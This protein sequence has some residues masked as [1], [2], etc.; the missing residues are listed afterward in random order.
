MTETLIHA[1]TPLLLW[2]GLGLILS[3]F[4]P[5]SLPRL[6]GRSLYWVGVPLQIL[7]LSRQTNLSGSAGVVPLIVLGALIIGFTLA[8]LSWQIWKLISSQVDHSSLE[9]TGGEEERGKKSHYKSST[10]SEMPFLE[11]ENKNSS[12]FNR[13][14]QGSFIL[15]GM[16]GNTGFVGL[17]LAPSFLNSHAVSLAI[18][19]S[20]TNNVIGT[21]GLGVFIASYFSHSAERNRWWMQLRDVLTVPSLWAFV[22]GYST[23][24][25]ELP[26]FIESG[27]NAFIAL[28]IGISFTLM[29]IRLAQLKGWKSFQT[30]LL[31][32]LVKVVV[33]PALVG[34][35]TTLMGL[36]GD[37][38]L[39]MV[40]M[41]G[42]PTAFA[43]LILAEE[44][45]LDRELAASCIVV[46]TGLLLLILPLWLVV[47]D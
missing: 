1:Y 8:C 47:F 11:S 13:S 36:S 12:F 23:R 6:L 20:V 33:M 45:E 3:K 16:L 15:A 38:R 21:Y 25:A 7:A 9:L 24:S 28:V 40:L 17:A 2:T 41:A 14:R 26:V 18:F 5:N 4:V 44:Y 37:A 39:A 19:Y 34:V 32:S 42:V 22:I 46:T 43:S 10:N 29:G 27:L 31:P 35:A 30:A